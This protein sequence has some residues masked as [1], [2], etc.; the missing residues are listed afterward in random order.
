MIKELFKNIPGIY[1][2][3]PKIL[4]KTIEDLY[5]SPI[6][7]NM[8]LP[9]SDIGSL[10]MLEATM[11]ISFLKIYNPIEIFEFGTFLGF[12]TALLVKNSSV[13]STVYSLDLD[14]CSNQNN[15]DFTKL[16][17]KDILGNDL[18]NDA[19][20]SN[21]Q[22]IKGEFFLKNIIDSEKKKIKLLKS[23]SLDLDVLHL[24]LFKK[25][26]FCFIDGGHN[27][28]IVKS[29]TEKAFSMCKKNSLIIWHDYNS[30]IHGDVTLYLSVLSKKYEIFH[31]ANTML[32][33]T[34][35]K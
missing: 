6:D 5:D 7:F 30:K 24:G 32:A 28:D 33:F 31:I 10:T 13:N 4:L 21:I 18:I 25:I 12:T 3:R 35:V 9:S 2:I 26:D 11:I 17:D 22:F 34:I 29:D 15:F 8:Y 27:Y 14:N 23:N 16:S 19:F 1:E 20:L